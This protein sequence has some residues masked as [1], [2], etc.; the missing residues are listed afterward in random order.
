MPTLNLT[1]VGTVVVP[2]TSLNLTQES[3]LDTGPQELIGEEMQLTK[4]I[5]F[6]D[7]SN[8]IYVGEA[9]PG[10]AETAAK[11]R[12]KRLN[13]EAGLDGDIEILFANGNPS[14][15][16]RWDERLTLTYT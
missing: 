2:E 12:I 6:V 7:A 1:Q 13:T 8:F 10:T 16:N 15:N 4:R 9:L 11:W 5:D 3:D 14:F